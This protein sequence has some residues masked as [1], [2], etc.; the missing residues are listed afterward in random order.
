MDVGEDWDGRRALLP[1]GNMGLSGSE[2]GM[3]NPQD[4]FK[5][6]SLPIPGFAF[7]SFAINDLCDLKQVS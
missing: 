5:C 2:P 7:L 3:G 4:L 6:V 1:L